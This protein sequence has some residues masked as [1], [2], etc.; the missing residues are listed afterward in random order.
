M[1]RRILHT[2]LLVGFVSI[3]SIAQDFAPPV[4]Q[5]LVIHSNL[6]KE[7]RVI[8]VRMPADFK[9]STDK[10]P[11][12]YLMD[13]G[14]HINE[15][16]STIDFLVDNQKI[17]PLIVVGINNT[18]R[19]RDLTPTHADIKSPDGNTIM[20]MPTSGGG[21][22]F[23]DFIQS[24]LIP[25]IE[26]RYA[27]EPYRILA[28]HSLGGLLAIHA[29]ITRPDLFNAYIAVSPSLQW[30]DERTLHQAQ[31]FF[32]GQKELKRTLFFSLGNEGNVPNQMGDAFEQLQKTL[33][34]NSPKGFV[35]QSARFRDEDHGST[36][37]L[38]HYAALHTIFANWQMPRDL[39]T[40]L[41][42][43]GLAGIE[44]HYRELSER[45]G[46]SVSS[47][48]AINQLGYALLARKKVD[49]ALTVFKRNVELYP[50]SAN[51][52]DSLADGFEAAGEWE[53][54]TQ[55]AQKAVE[56]GVAANDPRAPDFKK[57]LERLNAA[58]NTDSKDAKRNKSAVDFR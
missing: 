19:T 47:E 18:D 2:I 57:H 44:Q 3:A 27:T 1:P 7:D 24:E 52:Y 16:G 26:K 49:E 51:V 12:L 6:L 50:H 54:A 25:E 17:P 58:K 55:N 20:A 38:A 48:S 14:A 31:Q 21:D 32:A 15:I 34:A 9:Q 45:Y 46:F 11:V 22:R 41:P 42:T 5:R 23:L 53:L 39:A 28:G 29:L 35:V 37:L 43:G 56:A 36:V 4:P 10:Y 8:L 30:D 13:G 33:S 40:G